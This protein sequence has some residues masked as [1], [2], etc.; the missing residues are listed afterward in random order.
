[1]NHHINKKISSRGKC[2]DFIIEQ[3]IK[4]AERAAATGNAAFHFLLQDATA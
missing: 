2:G 1:M 4:I 3:T